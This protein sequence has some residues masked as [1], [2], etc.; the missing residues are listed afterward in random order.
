[1]EETLD[2]LEK[3]GFITRYSV[4]D[5]QYGVVNNWSRHQIPGKNEPPSEIPSFDGTITAYFRP[6]TQTERLKVYERDGWTCLYCGAELSNKR[7][8]LCLDHVIPYSRGG[9]NRPQNLATACKQC[10]AIKGDRTPDEAN[11]VWPEGLGETTNTISGDTDGGRKGVNPS[12]TGG[13]TPPD[14]TL[15]GGQRTPDGTL[16]GGQRTPDGGVNGGSTYHERHRTGG[17]TGGQIVRT[18]GYCLADLEREREREKEKEGEK[19]NTFCPEPRSASGLSAP[20]ISPSAPLQNPP[21][22]VCEIPVIGPKGFFEITQAM[23][24]E[25]QATF[26]GVDV[27]QEIRSCRA[28]NMANPTRQKTRKGVARHIVSWLQRAQDRGG[29]VKNGKVVIGQTKTFAGNVI[30]ISQA[31]QDI[32]GGTQ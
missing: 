3:E 30:A 26:P 12:L 7:R 21:V 24:E 22:V 2:I 23:V 1:M 5:N 17:L 15:T 4:E 8:A 10:N 28:W 19:D 31:I 9:T 13:Q 29:G 11:M 16:T 20:V 6:L 27:I 18:V 14:G 25:W 32:Q